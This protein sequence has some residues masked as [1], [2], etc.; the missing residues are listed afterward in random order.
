[1]DDLLVL[2]FIVFCGV[3]AYWWCV[4]EKKIR[5]TVNKKAEQLYRNHRYQKERQQEILNQTDKR[6]QL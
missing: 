6:E 5:R 1:M 4:V 3:I 2:L